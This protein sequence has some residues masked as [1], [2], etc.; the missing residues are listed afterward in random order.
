MSEFFLTIVNMSI[1]ASWIVLA[2]LLLRLLL[3]KAPKWITVLLWGIVAVRL[4]CPFTIESVMSLIPS[5]E[6]ISPEIMM[7][8]TPEINSGIPVFN[9]FVNPVISESFSPN[10]VM[11]ANPLQILIPILSIVWL[12]GIAGMLLYTAISYFRV[13]RKIGTAVLLR[14]NVFQSENVVSPFVLGIVNPKIYLPFN[15]N[16]QDMSHVIAH[17]Q[18]H[19][20]RKD[21]WWKPFGF[22]LLT[23]HW[24][25]PLM[26]LGYVLLCRDIELAC[27]EKVIK[28]LNTEQKADY[29]QALLT[30]SV[31]RRMIAACPLAFGEVGV[32]NRV[33]SVLN[34]K[35]PAFWIVV[36]AIVASIVVAVC[37]L[38][39]PKQDTDLGISSQK[40]GSDLKGITLEII[41]TDLS[42][43]DPFIK[44][45]WTNDTD[46]K[47]TYGEEFYIYQNINDAWEDCRNDSNSAWDSVGYWTLPNS[48]SEKD[49]HLNGLIMTQTGK[50][51]FE[52]EFSVDGVSDQKYKAWIEFKL[53]KG[54]P[55]ITVHTFKAVELVYYHGGYSFLQTAE[56]APNYRIVNNMQLYEICDIVYPCG[57]LES[58]TLDENNFDSR[59]GESGLEWTDGYSL[60]EI[61]KNNRRAWQ[62]YVTKGENTDLYLVLEQNDGTFYIGVGYANTNPVEPI[63]SDKSHIRWFYKLESVSGTSGTAIEQPAYDGSVYFYPSKTLQTDRPEYDKFY[64]MPDTELNELLSKLEKGKW[65]WDALTDRT[66]FYFDGQIYYDGRWIYFGFEQE[67]FY[68][69]YNSAYSCANANDAIAQMKKIYDKA[70]KYDPIK[71]VT[72]VGGA[73]GPVNM[74]VTV[75]MD[76]LKSKFPNYFGL[77]TSKGLEVY[78][79]QMAEGSYSCGLLPGK[80]LNYT[81]EELWNLHKSSASL[82]EMRAIIADYMV[83]VNVSKSDIVIRAIG[84]PHSSYAYTIDD[85]YRRKL[86][87]LFWSEIPIVENTKYSPIIDTATFDIDGDGK[88][89]Q[90]SLSY[91]PTSGLFTFILSVSENGKLEYYNIYNGLAG[92]M[93]FETTTAGTKL[94]LV[95]QGESEPIDYSFSVKDGN[96]VLTANGENVAYWGEQG[97]NSKYAPKRISDLNTAIAEVLN[98]KH[99]AEKPD[100]LI[101]IEN[102]YLLANETASGTPLKGN[103][104]HMEIAN[105][106]LLVYH[107]KYSVNGEHL[108]EHEGDFVPTAITFAIDKNGEYTLEDYWTPQTGANFEKDVRSKFP[109][110]SATEALNTEKYAEDL[111]KENWRLANEYFSQIKNTSS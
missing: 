76:Q 84:M 68:Y 33:K 97:V 95:P 82:D 89:E 46:K 70:E 94:H 17:E 100:G 54:V 31:N 22:L 73:D 39:N 102:Y 4:V 59:F 38:T 26:W 98:E 49:Y 18:A 61:K 62:T 88:N 93:S 52:T 103:S 110:S 57:K 8:A 15:M 56:M 2:V 23:I 55:G 81:Q 83:N 12:V 79:W 85:E 72:N 7:D 28:E 42:A 14:D 48:A 77:T 71:D 107:M 10:P 29:S 5:A 96:I 64:Q 74:V 37:F 86:N 92:E 25:N 32:K 75:D 6:T 78:I 27:D 90:C 45:K 58:I 35:K 87:E 91:G 65:V 99:R 16:E 3:K 1:S 111:I 41:D 9:N 105:V 63:N 53:E 80:N 43:P 19:I 69:S 108:E 24:F 30:C 50:Y 109:G 66:E 34:Y 47:I 51:R 13:K 67:V 44:V 104:G 106:Y 36:I 60:K 11:S 40:S 20:R 21:H 101:H